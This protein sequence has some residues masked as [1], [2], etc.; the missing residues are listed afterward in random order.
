MANQT[1]MSQ[2]KD[3]PTLCSF[4][5]GQSD[6]ERMGEKKAC[7]VWGDEDGSLHLSVGS[8][9]SCSNVSIFLVL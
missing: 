3:R 6:K 8:D 4:A 1:W 5:K 2:R 9:T 7:V